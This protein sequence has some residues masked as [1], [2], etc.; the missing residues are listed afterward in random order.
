MFRERE[1]TWSAHA[2]YVATKTRIHMRTVRLKTQ[3]GT[4]RSAHL[5]K[6]HSIHTRSV[7]THTI[8]VRTHMK[9]VT[10]AANSAGADNGHGPRSK[11]GQC[12]LAR[13]DHSTTKTGRSRN[14]PAAK[15]TLKPHL[16]AASQ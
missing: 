16:A 11:Q 14:C 8:I 9:V 2:T 7:P 13:I 12:D 6:R 10:S 5:S 4:Q 15:W 1:V 3:A